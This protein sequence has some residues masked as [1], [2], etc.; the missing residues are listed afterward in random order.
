MFNAVLMHY[1]RLLESRRKKEVCWH[2]I[3]DK[4]KKKKKKTP[5]WMQLSVKC[6]EILSCSFLSVPM[7]R[8]SITMIIV[9]LIIKKGSS[10]FGRKFDNHRQYVTRLSILVQPQ[11]CLDFVV[12]PMFIYFTLPC[13]FY[14]VFHRLRLTFAAKIDPK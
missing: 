5:H 1:L 4:K 11:S 13:Q 10:R 12:L 7:T 8:R 14:V 3:T 9:L 6:R 2:A